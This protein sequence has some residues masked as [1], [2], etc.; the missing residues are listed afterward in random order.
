MGKN[1]NAQNIIV[2][3]SESVV[4]SVVYIYTLDYFRKK[5][6][7]MPTP[8]SIIFSTIVAHFT[9]KIASTVVKSHLQKHLD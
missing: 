7:I 3:I 2:T 5:T 6:R 8:L 1:N 9:A 4:D